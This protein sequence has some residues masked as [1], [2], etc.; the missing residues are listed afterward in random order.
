[1]LHK[2]GR[3]ELQGFLL[4]ESYARNVAPAQMSVPQ[5][6][7]IRTIEQLY[8]ERDDSGFDDDI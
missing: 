6:S 4:C 8:E 7:M 1:V 2:E 5:G 3:P